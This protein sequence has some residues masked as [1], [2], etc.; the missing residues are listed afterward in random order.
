ML[1]EC[2]VSDHKD[3]SHISQ[4]ISII[5]RTANLL[6]KKVTIVTNIF[7]FVLSRRLCWF[8]LVLNILGDESTQFS[9]NLKRVRNW[10]FKPSSN[11]NSKHM[12]AKGISSQESFAMI[13]PCVADSVFWDGHWMTSSSAKLDKLLINRAIFIILYLIHGDA[14]WCWTNLPLW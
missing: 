11:W 9:L 5:C 4:G 7:L 8:N 14:H 10:M 13:A 1:A 6:H 2:I 3:I 12:K